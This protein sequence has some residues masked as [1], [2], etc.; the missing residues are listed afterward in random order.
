MLNFVNPYK[1]SY[2]ICSMSYFVMPEMHHILLDVLKSVYITCSVLNAIILNCALA[3]HSLYF[4]VNPPMQ[5]SLP[6]CQRCVYVWTALLVVYRHKVAARSGAQ[7]RGLIG[8]Q[9]HTCYALTVL[10]VTKEVT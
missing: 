8:P 6:L 4:L 10:R 9:S 1:Q 5:L 3:R 7:R 2:M